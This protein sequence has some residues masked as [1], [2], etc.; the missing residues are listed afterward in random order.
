VTVHELRYRLSQLD[1][2]AHVA[3]LWEEHSESKTHLETCLFEISHVSMSRGTPSRDEEGRVGFTFD[4]IGP[5]NW[6]FIAV[7]PA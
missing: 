7:T 2:S 1:G 4:G 6:L 3:V 5:A